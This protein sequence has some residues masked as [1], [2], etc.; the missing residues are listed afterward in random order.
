M[1]TL[2][3]KKTA[4]SQ[5][6]RATRSRRPR[7]SPTLRHVAPTLPPPGRSRPARP[8]RPKKARKVALSHRWRSPELRALAAKPSRCST[9]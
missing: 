8:R 6:R 3:P 5:L 9:C 2:L 1:T 4:P 7:K